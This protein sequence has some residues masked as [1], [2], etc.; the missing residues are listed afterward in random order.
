M[1]ELF[2][3]KKKEI[4]DLPEI[5]HPAMGRLHGASGVLQGRINYEQGVIAVSINPDGQPIEASLSLAEKVMKNIAALNDRGRNLVA[6]H[7]LDAYNA[8]W[9]FGERVNDGGILEMFAKPQ[10]SKAE[11]FASLTL[12]MVQVTGS[13]LVTLSFVCAEMP[14]GHHVSVSSTDEGSFDNVRIDLYDRAPLDS[15]AAST[16]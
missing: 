15:Q 14:S 2:R 1:F 16:H 8:E 11:F 3:A 10:K 9:R 13:E 4:R 6:A 5:D 12:S 7:A